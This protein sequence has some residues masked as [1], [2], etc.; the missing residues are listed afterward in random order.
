MRMSQLP[1]YPA[2]SP[3]G[4]LRKRQELPAGSPEESPEHDHAAS[5]A[6]RCQGPG[7]LFAC[8]FHK[9]YPNHK[10]LDRLC[11]KRGWPTFHRLKEHVL[12]K[13]PSLQR[14]GQASSPRPVQ[15]PNLNPL[16]RL[17]PEAHD[18]LWRRRSKR[19]TDEQKWWSLYKLQFGSSHNVPSPYVEQVF[20][21]VLDSLVRFS[22]SPDQSSRLG[23][24]KTFQDTLVRL[25]YEFRSNNGGH[26]SRYDT[27]P[28]AN[29][30]LGG[31][32]AIHAGGPPFG[33][34]PGIVRWQSPE[35]PE[36]IPTPRDLLPVNVFKSSTDPW[37]GLDSVDSSCWFNITPNCHSGDF[38]GD[39]AD[40]LPT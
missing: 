8:P 9:A 33:V 13:H 37:S 2:T 32:D 31:Q 35:V 28:M 24:D 10:D 25:V 22:C 16:F 6:P 19:I 12:R 7:R 20:D 29:E 21:D 39:L 38:D 5:F 40:L 3:M 30:T 1:N 18:G 11:T 23:L 36:E 15:I 26:L 4:L 27:A 17:S 14:A 34:L